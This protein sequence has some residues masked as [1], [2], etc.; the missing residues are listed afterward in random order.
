[1]A[2]RLII[3]SLDTVNET[4]KHFENLD[5][6]FLQQY[7]NINEHIN[8]LETYL[9]EKLG[10]VLWSTTPTNTTKFNPKVYRIRKYNDSIN[11]KIISEF[12]H[13]P[14][15]S[16]GYP[17]R[18]NLAYH[19]VFYCSPSA[20][21]ALY[22][23]IESSF[24]KGEENWYYLSEWSFR[25]DEPINLSFFIHGDYEFSD[26]FNSFSQRA[27][28]KVKEKI[29]DLT[30][31]ESL[32]LRQILKTYSNLFEQ[33]KNY[34]FSSFLGHIHLYN[35]SNLRADLFAYP[36]IQAFRGAINFAIHPNAVIHKLILNRVY[37]VKVDS[38]DLDNETKKLTTH[39]TIKGKVGINNN[40]GYLTWIDLHEKDFEYFKTLLPEN[41]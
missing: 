35:N 8:K 5:W 6:T 22:E 9:V 16:S 26:F 7:S 36:S 4:I 34:L 30:T 17:Q 13:P 23:T 10:L 29:P 28:E 15:A 11:T 25:P 41:K 14:A 2:Q 31:D 19:P 32:S 12:S 20:G 33:K 39:F 24:T 38:Y 21:T 3:P 37:L 27:F 18:A 40:H 1:M